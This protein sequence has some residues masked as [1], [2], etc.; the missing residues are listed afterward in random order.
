MNMMH[1]ETR[2]EY[3]RIDGEVIIDKDTRTG[4][5]RYWVNGLGY[6]SAQ[7]ATHEDAAYAAQKRIA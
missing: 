1:N 3:N 5:F 7:Y 4:M 2:Y 6:G